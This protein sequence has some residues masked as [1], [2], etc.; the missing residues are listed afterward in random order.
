MTGAPAGWYP[1]EGGTLRYWD[2]TRWTDH[3]TPAR[4]N[5]GPAQSDLPARGQLPHVAPASGDAHPPGYEPPYNRDDPRWERAEYQSVNPALPGAQ[6][7]GAWQRDPFGRHELRWWDGR[8]WTHH[9]SSQGLQGIDPPGPGSQVSTAM[10]GNAK[11][12]QQVRSLG[13]MTQAAAVGSGPLF[14]EPILVVNQKAKL[15][16]VKAEYAVFDQHGR[17]IGA[18]RQ[19]GENFMKKAMAPTPE[20]NR[21]RRLEIVDLNGG[22]ILKLVRPA[23]VVKS[24]VTVS[25]GDG[26]KIGEIVQENT[27]AV[28]GLVRGAVGLADRLSPVN[29]ERRIG[30]L[31]NVRFS[32]EARGSKLGS[33]QIEDREQWD[34][35][36][37]DM[38][39]EELARITRTWAGF[40]R[41]MFTKADNY[42]V[43]IHRPLEQPL[44]SLVI[45]AA[46]AVDT[47]FRQ[48]D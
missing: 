15:F 35:R 26:S 2:G 40:A 16:E 33:I 37:Q 8:V 3:V 24:T 17:Q 13:L 21:T 12:Q 4:S 45:A 32:L 41:E 42:V 5:P 27:R 44:N 10:P 30:H 38:A 23:K 20:A 22:V 28:S 6:V 18:V 14:T 11:V 1:Q 36:I 48:D 39:G 43:Q 46:L 29:L 31:A 7:Q 25:A 34:F 19:I 9:V 47:V